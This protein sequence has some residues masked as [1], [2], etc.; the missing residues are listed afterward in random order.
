MYSRKCKSEF[1]FALF[2]GSHLNEELSVWRTFLEI[3][4]LS[5]EDPF[6]FGA[7][8]LSICPSLCWSW[9]SYLHVTNQL[10]DSDAQYY[11]SNE[12]S[13]LSFKYSAPVLIE[14]AYQ[15]A[16]TFLMLQNRTLG[17]RVA[18]HYFELLPC[19]SLI[20]IQVGRNFVVKMLVFPFVLLASCPMLV[21]S[22][23]VCFQLPV[24]LLLVYTDSILFT[25]YFL[26]FEVNF[27]RDGNIFHLSRKHYLFSFVYG[28]LCTPILIKIAKNRYIF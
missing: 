24:F 27:S 9:L 11:K 8:V 12:P 16:L 23:P 26:I 5:G 18:F 6:P 15:C 14:S 2:C 7:K 28:P 20:L 25:F 4:V 1:I 21:V 17:K 3:E 19:L 22:L 10:I 13:L